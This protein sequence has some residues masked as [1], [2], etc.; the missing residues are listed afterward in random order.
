L[1]YRSVLQWSTVVALGLIVCSC[2][3]GQADLPG[4]NWILNELAVTWK[5]DETQWIVFAWVGWCFAATAF[6]STGARFGGKSQ[7]ALVSLSALVLIAVLHYVRDYS[8]AA[9]SGRALI[10]VFTI[11]MGRTLA[12]LTQFDIKN[13][14]TPGSTRFIFPILIG[15]LSVLSLVR[16][17]ASEWT[18]YHG[19]ARQTG[20][21]PNPNSFGVLMAFAF[22][23]CL[24]RFSSTAFRFSKPAQDVGQFVLKSL[25]WA[26]LA[27]ISSLGLIRSLSRGAWVAAFCGL[28]FLAHGIWRKCG[29]SRAWVHA[30]QTNGLALAVIACAMVLLMIWHARSAE[31]V[32]VSRLFSIG[33]VNDFSWRNRLAAWEGAMEMIDD[34]PVLGVGWVEIQSAYGSFYRPPKIDENTAIILNDYL[35]VGA[36]LGLPALACFALYLWF[37]FSPH[38]ATSVAGAILHS[39]GGEDAHWAFAFGAGAVVFLTSFFFDGGMFKLPIAV[40]FWIVTELMGVLVRSPV[41][42]VAAH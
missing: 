9:H 30:V 21:W 39:E 40:L 23:F 14:R 8:T 2:L 32:L 22:V 33:N 11:A 31:S 35:T 26:A 3:I 17:S 20:F 6:L 24:G 38:L 4:A 27:G 5:H 15:F 10:F 12:T 16:L 41:A 1:N 13:G 7:L 28:L 25:P 34:H 18:A 42:K 36:T 29:R 37:S 19:Q